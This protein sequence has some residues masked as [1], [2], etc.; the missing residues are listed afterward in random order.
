MKQTKSGRP[1]LDKT[2]GFIPVDRELK[3]DI[4]QYIVKSRNVNALFKSHGIAAQTLK[5]ILK[6]EFAH[7]EQVRMI[8]DFIRIRKQIN[9]GVID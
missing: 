3:K 2:Q 9:A 7:P 1:F 6:R 5:D 4:Q 8:S